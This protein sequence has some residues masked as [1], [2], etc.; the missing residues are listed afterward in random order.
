MIKTER[1]GE[2]G[3]ERQREREK[4]EGRREREK[5]GREGEKE[6]FLHT[7]DILNTRRSICTWITSYNNYPET[8]GLSWY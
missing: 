5:E 7:Y 3:R 2:G 6:I 8:R 4:E 1:G